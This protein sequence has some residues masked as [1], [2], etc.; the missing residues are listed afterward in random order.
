MA[1]KEK[2]INVDDELK[3][4]KEKKHSHKKHSD[5]FKVQINCYDI[6]GGY[7]AKLAKDV[8]GIPLEGIWYL[9]ILSFIIF[10]HHFSFLFSLFFFLKRNCFSF[11][12][13]HLLSFTFIYFNLRHTGVVVY[14]REYY[15][16]GDIQ[17]SEPV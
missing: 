17:R 15:W 5:L 14:G 2:E 7:A 10:F 1:K 9:D 11:F 12:I 13:F 4:T 6:S 3:M 16:S 8:I